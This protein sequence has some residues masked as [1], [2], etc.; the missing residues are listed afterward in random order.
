MN[1]FQHLVK[2]SISRE[3]FSKLEYEFNSNNV[4][5][6]R[7]KHFEFTF[8]STVTNKKIPHKLGFLPKDVIQTFL[9]GDGTVTWNYNNF[10]DTMIDISISGTVSAT[11][12]TTVRVFLGRYENTGA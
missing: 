7:F 10:T 3:N 12:P 1:L 6:S 4:L 2:D 8:T 9:L 5:V 11:N